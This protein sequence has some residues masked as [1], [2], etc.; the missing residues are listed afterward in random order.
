MRDVQRLCFLLLSEW[1]QSISGPHFLAC[2]LAWN[3]CICVCMTVKAP[4]VGVELIA[5]SLRILR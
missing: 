1:E 5:R 4:P 3:L 2:R